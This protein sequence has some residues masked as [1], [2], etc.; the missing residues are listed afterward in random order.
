MYI[1]ALQMPMMMMMM[2]IEYLKSDGRHS[3]HLLY[4]EDSH[5]NAISW[6]SFWH[7]ASCCTCSKVYRRCGQIYNP[8]AT[9]FPRHLIYQELL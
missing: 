1:G 3:V 4:S 7:R 8:S 5:L 2:M 9:R 6:D